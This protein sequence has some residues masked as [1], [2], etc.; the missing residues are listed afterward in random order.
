VLIWLVQHV[1]VV[2]C[3]SNYEGP[4]ALHIHTFV[5]TD[6]SPV[7]TTQTP[8]YST[9][10]APDDLLHLERGGS[11]RFLP[12]RVVGAW[13]LWGFRFHRDSGGRTWAVSGPKDLDLG[14]GCTQVQ[15]SRSRDRGPHTS[16]RVIRSLALV[17]FTPTL[18]RPRP[19]LA[20][21][22]LSC[23]Y[24]ALRSIGL[25]LSTANLLALLRVIS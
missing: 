21:G 10:S 17:P 19:A 1:K 25:L 8:R 23:I 7:G 20:T 16:V 12:G 15:E 11:F 18:P 6:H 13:V 24:S 3:C 22:E 9:G 5:C 2:H 4:T 14:P